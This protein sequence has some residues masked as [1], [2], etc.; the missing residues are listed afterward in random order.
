M[1]QTVTVPTKT[2][3]KILSRLDLLTQEVADIKTRLFKKEPTYGSDEWWE[4]S[5]KKA[6]EEI[7]Q[8]KGITLHNKKELKEFFRNLKNA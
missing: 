3:E 2:F 8:G 4:W 5:D 1:N 6:M 7:K